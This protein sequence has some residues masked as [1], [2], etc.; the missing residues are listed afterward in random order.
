MQNEKLEQ[1]KK[2]YEVFK[3]VLKLDD[4]SREEELKNELLMDLLLR[5]TMEFRDENGILY[6]DKDDIFVYCG[7]NKDPDKGYF[8]SF[9]GKRVNTTSKEE[10]RD[11]IKHNI[12]L[13]NNLSFDP[14]TI[15]F[16]ENVLPKIRADFQLKAFETDDED[17]AK[18]Y[19]LGKYAHI[20]KSSELDKII[21]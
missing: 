14:S 11:F 3:T 13:F 5:L 12:V 18:I 9:G 20:H 2:S 1:I 7:N 10:Y 8:Y 4:I 6:D 19:V 17:K 15:Y 16:S 21:N